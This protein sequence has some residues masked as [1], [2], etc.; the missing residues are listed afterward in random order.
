[1]SV[2]QRAD[3]RSLV[4]R[5]FEE[6]IEGSD[7]FRLPDLTDEVLAELRDDPQL[8]A[9][10]VA[11]QLR[12]MVYA[13]GQQMLTF[14]RRAKEADGEEVISAGPISI[15]RT[16]L[17]AKALR[18]R[19][20]W[21]QHFE[22]AGD[23]QVRLTAMTERD[24]TLAIEERSKRIATESHFVRFLRT[25]RAELSGDEK[26]EDKFTPERLQQVYEQC[27]GRP[28]RSTTARQP[29]AKTT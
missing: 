6:R 20:A 17:E 5:M 14:W 26:V 10:F 23:R 27:R 24:C 18:R 7:E 3:S 1:M 25:L 19:L 16:G 22:Q 11:Q 21:L 13:V 4:R 28:S 15:T 29:K 2:G 12:P 9:A 8:L